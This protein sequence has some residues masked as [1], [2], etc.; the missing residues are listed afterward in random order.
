MTNRLVSAFALVAMLLTPGCVCDAAKDQAGRS[1]AAS[2]IYAGLI[3]SALDGSIEA[4]NGK[5]VTADDL[6]ATPA[7]VKEL[8]QNCVTAVYVSRNGWHQ[9]NF[10][11]NDGPDPKTLMLDQPAFPE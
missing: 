10:A 9:V 3:E 5:P 6:A 2:D 1:A 7:S 4:P 11:I 8:L